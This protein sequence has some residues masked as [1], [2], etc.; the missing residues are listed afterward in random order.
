M[1]RTILDIVL[2]AA[3]GMESAVWRRPRALE[4]HLRT[5]SKSVPP[6][7][8]GS[9]Q[10]ACGAPTH[11]SLLVVAICSAAASSGLFAQTPPGRTIPVAL[12]TRTGGALRGLVVDHDIHGIVVVSENVPYVFA[13]RELTGGSSFAA[14]RALLVLARG[15]ES[16]L[17]AADHYDLGMFALAQERTDI[18]TKEFR[19]ATR[20]D[21]SFKARVA[22]VWDSYRARNESLREDGYTI[23]AAPKPREEPGDA[24]PAGRSSKS[25]S[26]GSAST[27]PVGTGA[28]AG[29]LGELGDVSLA[30]E[31][32]A[33]IRE[34]VLE[35]Y[36]RFGEKV[37]ETLGKDIVLLETDHF[38]IWT[39]WR[40][41]DRADL[42]KWCEAMY[43]ALCEQFDLDPADSVFLAKC[44]VFCFQAKGRFRR[45]A[46][47]FDGYGAKSAVGYTRSIE[48]NGHVHVVLVRQGR[49]EIDL[50]RFAS[51]LVHEGTHAF[52]HRLYSSTLLPPWVN[53]G[54]AE[55]IVERVLAERSVTGENAKLL[56]RQYVR[57]DW[58]IGDFLESAA[59]LAVHRY[60]LAHSIVSHVVQR[61]RERF[62][63]FVRGLKEGRSVPEALANAYD[64][65][66][67]DG[68]E[69]SWRAWVRERDPRLE[70]E[71]RETYPPVGP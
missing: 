17:T 33:E 66:T 11:G 10:R 34:R 48:A 46:Q 27:V 13:W 30:R 59:P 4:V 6:R 24:R 36:R 62:A 26:R 45:F 7:V 49:S 20:R 32:T 31:P 71:A 41:R 19:E 25:N 53:E 58:P 3:G 70:S 35:V 57:H 44:P 37:R 63:D 47:K 28:L 22:Q 2:R 23:Q 14:K 43:G 67:I 18:A 16:R 8:G 52:L 29:V 69:R 55:L 51:T 5:A 61:G 54:Y 68:L 21:R 40:R 64:G 38:L 9:F 12:Q 60:A 65:L 50:D 15:E 56:A 1:S 39:D 42:S